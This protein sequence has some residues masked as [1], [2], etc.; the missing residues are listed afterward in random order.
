MVLQ[1][2]LKQFHLI[3][4]IL[5][6]LLYSL[7]SHLV[8]YPLGSGQQSVTGFSMDNDYNSLWTIKEPHN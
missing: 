8:N 4:S 3:I 5:H 2:V 1:S 7:H 6:K